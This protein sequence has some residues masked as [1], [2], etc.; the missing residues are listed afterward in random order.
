[1]EG[2]KYPS[3]YNPGKMISPLHYIVELICEKN[4]KY[5]KKEI[6]LKFW[7][8]PIWGQF[9]RFQMARAKA[10]LEHY[11][12]TAIIQALNDKRMW[13]VY[14]LQAKWLLPIIQ[15][16]QEKLNLIV[17]KIEG[18]EMTAG[19]FKRKSFKKN[20]ILEELDG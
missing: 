18:P 20:N 14:S 3:R 17:P 19:T 11:S 2:K 13:N 7:T 5:T 15:E 12:D 4:A 9:Y 10:L 1:M 8:L 16:Y 6:P